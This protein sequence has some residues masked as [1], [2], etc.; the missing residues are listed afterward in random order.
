MIFGRCPPSIRWTGDC[1]GE[2]SLS[3]VS[4]EAKAVRMPQQFVPGGLSMNTVIVHPERCV[5]CLQC[6]INCAAHLK[7]FHRATSLGGTE[8]LV[9]H[10][11]SIEPPDTLTP[12]NLLRISVGLEDVADLVQDLDQALNGSD[13]LAARL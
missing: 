3:P 9:E 7:V 5:G 8:S 11:A 4:G 6:S 12:R 2:G 13:R 10:R 1:T